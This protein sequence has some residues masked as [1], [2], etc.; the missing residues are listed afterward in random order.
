MVAIHSPSAEHEWLPVPAPRRPGLHPPRR[1]D[2]TARRLPDRA[3]R[4]RRR[5][6]VALVLALA[7]A[8]GAWSAG[9]ALV[10]LTRAGATEPQPIHAGEGLQ[11]GQD[12]VVR[13]GDTLWSIAEQIAPDSD[14]RQVVHALE[15]A[16]GDAALEV[17]DVLVLD[18]G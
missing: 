13:P 15:A 3:T 14:P 8:A 17:G 9:R 10:S 7:L 16:N 1:T 11:P 6:L 2:E 12:Y 18:A 5:R 4:I